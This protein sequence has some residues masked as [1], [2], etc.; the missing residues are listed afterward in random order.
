M[1]MTYFAPAM[2]AALAVFLAVDPLPLHSVATPSTQPSEW[3]SLFDGKSIS[4]WRGY[5]SPSVPDGWRV[6]DGTLAKD[7]PT[8]DLVSKD[9]FG[10]FELELEWKI[11]SGGNSGIF[12]R[13]NEDFDH[14]YWTAPE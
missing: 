13:G 8:G 4:A 6:V 1:R 3:Q 14:I 12:Y 2:G 5:K 10:D 7:K 11:A 9:E